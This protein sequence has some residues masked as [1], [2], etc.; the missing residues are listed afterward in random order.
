M[1]DN[2]A[3]D[4][5]SKIKR[6][7]GTKP[8]KL[9]V[10]SLLSIL[11]LLFAVI[12]FS[13]KFTPYPYTERD[14]MSFW[15]ADMIYYGEMSESGVPYISNLNIYFI[16]AFVAVVLLFV[17]A[18]A[19]LWLKDDG[20]IFY[21]SSLGGILLDLFAVILGIALD[22]IRGGAVACG[23]ISMLL[24]IA[25]MA[26]L[27]ISKRYTRGGNTARAVDKLRPTLT[28]SQYRQ[29]RIVMFA[30]DCA[31][32]LVMFIAFFVPLVTEVGVE[33][34]TY[35]VATAL[36]SNAPAYI[37][38]VLVVMVIAFFI[39]LL[40][41]ASTVVDFM[42]G[43]EEFV[44]RS[45]RFVTGA[46][47]YALAFFVLGF[48]LAFYGS[49]ANKAT[50][51]FERATTVSYIPLIFAAVA[52]LVHSVM[53]GRI[54]DGADSAAQSRAL[55]KVEPLI[56]AAAITLVTFVSLALNIVEINVTA[57]L[58]NYEESITL[59][60]YKL[61]GTYKDLS[62]GLQMLAFVEF[63]FLLTSGVLLLFGIISFL[64]KDKSY[65]KLIKTIIVVN[66]LFVLLIG[67]FGLYFKIAQKANEGTFLSILENN[68]VKITADM[69]NCEV[70][71]KTIFML[72]AGF[73]VIVVAMLRG[74]FGLTAESVEVD[75]KKGA[76]AGNGIPKPSRETVAQEE[77]DE[78]EALPT[79]VPDFDACPAFTELDARREQFGADINKRRQSLFDNPTLPEIVRFVVDYARE[80]R[81]HLSY[82]VE[83]IASFV[84]GMG[85]SRLSILQG[86]SGTGKTSLPKIFA[87]ALYGNCE[88]VE[89][90]S[91]WRDKNELLG[92]YNEFSKCFTP[93]KFTQCLYKA[94]L[95]MPVLTFI[96]LD[97]M[98][99]S[100]IEY[101][102]SDFLSL[103]EHEEDKREIKL[104]NVKLARVE[105][106]N[107]VE[108]K[109]LTDGHTLKI[110][111]NVWFVGTA[112]RDESTF[113]ISDK[114]YDR[115][116]TMNFNKRA[117]KVRSFGSPL[118]QRF[119][120]YGM[121]VQLFNDAKSKYKFEAE[122]NKLI[123]RTEQLLAPYNISFGNRVLKQ[124]EDFVKIYCA[125]FGEKSAVEKD[126]VERILLS[127][128]V[129][130]LETKVVENKEP[131]AAEFDKIGLK[132]CGE[133]VRR[134]NED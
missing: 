114:V 34:T 2:N 13:I 65:Y 20:R 93:K 123:Q 29:A 87:E 131:L 90:E 27:I 32:L 42:R 116:Q 108:Y 12:S 58:F 14:R 21:F 50:V 110:P 117:P 4:F 69:Y 100:R 98:N 101:Y 67:L 37:S 48:G 89:V 5:G 57:P 127:K 8:G 75:N 94:K 59:S 3:K 119:L 85:A 24:Y 88:I 70:S 80:S 78:A 95:S 82:S 102:F 112:N 103:M 124:I 1:N 53:Y 31:A 79:A 97:E 132:S 62:S 22:I 18:A 25:T 19:Y 77:K 115:A 55:L 84:A 47:A 68:G 28:Q 72:I 118:N 73:A 133:F 76:V 109:G 91:S 122:E 7:L 111:A 125:C 64:A 56:Y 61:L 17:A 33:K 120:P 81:L 23:V 35:I 49:I 129:S 43:G 126:A 54:V 113:E 96:V 40:A 11:G 10:L 60:G 105:N 26:A 44:T 128:V 86:M 45:R 107:R 92:Y 46:A 30:C 52:L 15:S 63:A 39:Q 74:V 36:R 106:G 66:I 121:L 104:L 38:V 99:L 51:G 83:D 71:S 41:F 6:F 9:I 130:K 16:I 134:L